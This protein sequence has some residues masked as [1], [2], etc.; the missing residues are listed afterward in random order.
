MRIDLRGVA[1]HFLP[2]IDLLACQRFQDRYHGR[3][4]GFAHCSVAKNP[5]PDEFLIVPLKVIVECL[6]YCVRLGQRQL[7][8]RDHVGVKEGEGAEVA[9]LQFH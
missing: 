3:L 1:E 8:F 4:D 6:G 7:Q 9:P 5:F 2:T